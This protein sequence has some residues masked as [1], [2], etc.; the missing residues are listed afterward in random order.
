MILLYF[1]LSCAHSNWNQS[2]DSPLLSFLLAN[3][4]IF[5][6]GGEILLGVDYIAAAMYEQ[7]VNPVNYDLVILDFWEH[8][9][10]ESEKVSIWAG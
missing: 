7:W 10:S 4:S 6:C 9:L 1:F 3:E 2:H 8:K 5:G